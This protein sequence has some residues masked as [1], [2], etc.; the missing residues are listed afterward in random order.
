MAVNSSFRTFVIE[1]LGRVTSGIRGR[2]MFG[3]VGIYAGDLFF[4]LIAEDTLYFKVDESNR[5]DFERAGMAP[6]QPAGDGGG[7]MQ[8]YRV[9]D[10]LLED[11][12]A[13]EPWVEKAVQVAARSR[14]RRTRRRD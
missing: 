5:S 13:L 12:E 1:Q 3:G 8:Y 7:V 11:V 4:A 2:A 6:F 14:Q 10:E 9:P